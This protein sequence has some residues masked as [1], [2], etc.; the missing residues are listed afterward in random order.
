M[1]SHVHLPE[2]MEKLDG[3]DYSA[4]QSIKGVY[5]FPD[6]MLLSIKFQRILM[7]LPI[8][9]SIEQEFLCM[10]QVLLKT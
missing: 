7:R 1:N 2:R 9:V 8:L 4:Y 3:S 10:T 6:F 5:D